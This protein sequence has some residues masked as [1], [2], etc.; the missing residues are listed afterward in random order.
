MNHS[1]LIVRFHGVPASAAMHMLM[2]RHVARLRELSPG[3]ERLQLQATVRRVEWPSRGP[4]V[5][6]LLR[7]STPGRMLTASAGDFGCSNAFM[8]MEAA[9]AQLRSHLRELVPHPPEAGSAAR[10]HALPER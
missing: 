6:V 10:V 2:E 5:Q 9:F 8:A 3:L 4:R 7:A 1:A